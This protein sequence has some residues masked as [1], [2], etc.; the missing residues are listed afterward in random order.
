MIMIMM[1]IMLIM[2]KFSQVAQGVAANPEISLTSVFIL[3]F[4]NTFPFFFIVSEKKTDDLFL[5][6]LNV[7]EQREA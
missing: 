2:I 4:L 7:R 6:I 3:L 1:M 5:S